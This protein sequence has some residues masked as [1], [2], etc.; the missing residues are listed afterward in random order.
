MENNNNNIDTTKNKKITIKFVLIMIGAF[1][2]GGVFGIVL[3]ILKK[4]LGPLLINISADTI[5]SI[6]SYTSTA[7]IVVDSFIPIITSLSLISKAK[8]LIAVWDEENDEEYIKIDKTLSN[9]L[10]ISS[11]CFTLNTILFGLSCYNLINS[12]HLILIVIIILFYVSNIF[13]TTFFQGKIV[14]IT[15]EINPEKEG[16]VL[17]TKFQKS[18]FNSCDEAERLMI[19]EGSYNT[20]KFMSGVYNATI[21][22]LTCVGM[23]FKIGIFPI[24]LVGI[25]YLMQVI[26]YAI[27]VQKLEN[28]RNN[29]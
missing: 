27:N 24:I 17:D 22:V 1:F 12:K 25:L 20:F 4:S 11:I 7:L 9:A 13:T 26:S 6:I 15:K 2:I 29:N 21:L 10:N 18:W 16:N 5:I 8:K 14:A 3:T 28:K 23:F 19:F